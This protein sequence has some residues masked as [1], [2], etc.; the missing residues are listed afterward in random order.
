MRTMTKIA[1]ATAILGAL[2]IPAQA[3]DDDRHCGRVAAGEWMSVSD[4]TARAASMGLDV[5]EVERDDG[6]YEVKGRD[7]EGRRVELKLHPA[8]A[9]IVKRTERVARDDRDDDWD[10]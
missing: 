7:G 8:T 6:C 3:D 1:C 5:R 10:D 9:E 4:I 2:A